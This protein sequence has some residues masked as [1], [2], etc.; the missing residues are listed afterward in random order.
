VIYT[1]LEGK[2]TI[3]WEDQRIVVEKGESILVP[4]MINNFVLSALKGDIAKLLE[5]YIK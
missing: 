5:V 2:Y 3:S 4:A 1:C